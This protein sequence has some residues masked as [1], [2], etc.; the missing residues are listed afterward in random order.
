MTDCKKIITS[1]L[2]V[3]ICS[4]VFSQTV[5]DWKVAELP[6]VQK[7]EGNPQMV[8]TP[9]GKAVVFGGNDAYFLDIN[10]LKGL[11]KFT[12]EAV[13]KPDSDGGFEQRFLHL[14]AVSGERVMFEIRVNRDNS[15]YFDTFITLSNGNRVT[16]IDKNLTHPTD[17]W[18]HAALVI[19]GMW[20]TVYIDGIAEFNEPFVFVPINE[21]MAS[22]GVR[23]NLTSW[24]KGSMFRLR[25]TP[26]A[27]TI[28][29]FLNDHHALNK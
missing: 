5:F 6:H 20:A 11:I 2:F 16:M 22:V 28:S 10:P 21:G 25:I 1:I 27:L 15:W 18:Y 7:T 26:R 4:T 14:G 23:Q 12:L 13:F 19:D 9:L 29:E 8:T 3:F 24:F 17:R